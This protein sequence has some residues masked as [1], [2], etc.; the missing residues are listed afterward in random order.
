M[1]LFRN[2][3]GKCSFYQ[4]TEHCWERSLASIPGFFLSGKAL[5]LYGAVGW[6]WWEVGNAFPQPQASPVFRTEQ[7]TQLSHSPRP[8]LQALF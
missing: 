8:Q 3:R 7:H 6:E 2:P 1:I 5:F 4:G